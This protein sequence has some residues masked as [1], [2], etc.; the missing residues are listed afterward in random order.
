M[1]DVN[2]PIEWDVLGEKTVQTAISHKYPLLKREVNLGGC[3]CDFTSPSGKTLIELKKAS[4]DKG[5]RYLTR[6]HHA[7]GQVLY[8]QSVMSSDMQQQLEDF[9]PVLLLFGSNIR[10]WITEDVRVFRQRH[11]VKLWAI[12]S[13]QNPNII[14]LDTGENIHLDLLA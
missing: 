14:D 10:K 3:F 1:I 9:T 8:Y 5:Q 4:S 12:V 2:L 13:L 11:R 6:P 7:I